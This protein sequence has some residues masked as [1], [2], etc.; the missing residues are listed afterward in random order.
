MRF[1]NTPI[2]GAWLIEPEPRGDERGTFTRRWCRDTLAAQGLLGTF[3][4]AN[5][6]TSR[7]AGT[8]RGLHYQAAPYAEAKLVA[9]SRGR[10]FD[11]LVDMRPESRTYRSWFGAE[12]SEENG[13]QMYV[14]EGCAH[15]YLTLVDNCVVTYPVT[16]PYTPMAERGVR[17][18]DPAIAIAWPMVPSVVSPKD[19]QWPLLEASR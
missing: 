4:Q 6:S 14:P 15:G 11:V 12:L 1:R 19:Q 5:E 7:V 16:A 8:L 9:C 3:V 13:L 17:W 18:N 10:V 2:A